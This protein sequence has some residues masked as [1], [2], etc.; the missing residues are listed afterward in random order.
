MSAS[1]GMPFSIS[2]SGAGACVTS[3]AQARQA[4]LGRRVTI[5]FSCACLPSG[6]IGEREFKCVRDPANDFAVIVDL[7]RLSVHFDS[8]IVAQNIPA[9]FVPEFATSTPK[10]V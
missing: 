10:T 6:S 8:M 4:Y 5:T 2:R 9:N 1:V 7:R 3:P